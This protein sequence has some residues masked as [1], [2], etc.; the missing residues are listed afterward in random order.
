MTKSNVL[1]RRLAVLV[2]ALAAVFGAAAPAS[3]A[4]ASEV[5]PLQLLS[6]I[7]N[8]TGISIGVSK[9]NVAGNYQALLPAH[10]RTDGSPLYWSRALSFYVGAGS[11]VQLWYYQAGSW[12]FSRTWAGA[13]EVFVG[14]SIAGESVARW[15]LRSHHA[16]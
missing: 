16:C 7:S 3:A 9:D 2:L 11:C 14:Q 15:A 1:T 6:Y 5:A 4:P 12:K 10:R 8:E 13:R